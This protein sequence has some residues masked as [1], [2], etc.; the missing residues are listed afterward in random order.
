MSDAIALIRDRLAASV[1]ELLGR[2]EGAAAFAELM[3]QNALPQVTPAAFVIPLGLQGGVA[4]VTTGLFR[5]EVQEIVGVMLVL[6]SYSTSGE[7]ALPELDRLIEAT[8][9][10]VVGFAPDDAV[11][12]FRLVRGALVSMTAGMIVYQLEFALSDQL[13]IAT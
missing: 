3:R 9:S 10:A 2:I 7:K 4:D 1:P 6:R 12:V 8:V 11:G 13:R 5:Q